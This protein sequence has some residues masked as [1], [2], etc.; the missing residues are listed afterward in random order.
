MNI[1]SKRWNRALAGALTLG[2]MLGCGQA[3]LADDKPKRVG[4]V[5]DI[6]GKQLNTN[7][8]S[9]DNRWYQ[10]YQS[11]PTLFQ[12]R[13]AAGDKT[14]AT[15]EFIVG[16]K[17]VIAPG[18]E[19]EIK[20]D[21]VMVVKSGTV[22]AQFDKKKLAGD[23]RKFEIRTAG[24]VMGIEGTEFI[25]QTNPGG[26]T[27]LTVIEGQVDVDGNKVGGGKRA[28]F[29]RTYRDEVYSAATNPI[30]S[31]RD[32]AFQNVDPAMRPVVNRAL[33]WTVGRTRLGR[34]FY[35]RNYWIARRALRAIDDPEG[36][37]VDYM[38]AKTPGGGMLRR[39]KKSQD[40]KPITASTLNGDIVGGLSW[41]KV[42]RTNQYAVVVANDSEA[43]D[44]VWYTTVKQS[45]NPSVKYPS[46][47]PELA[48]GKRYWLFVMPQKEK[49]GEY[50]PFY[51]K[52]RPLSYKG[53]FSSPGH[54][55]V[56]ADVSGVKAIGEAS[57][58]QVSWDGVNGANLYRVTIKDAAGNIVWS[59]EHDKS[60]YSYPGTARG[61]TPG[62]YV[63]SV[64][65]FDA[66]G[67]KMAETKS[68]VAFTS[69]GWTS[70]G[71]TDVNYGERTPDENTQGF[72]QN[73][74]SIFGNLISGF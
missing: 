34:F 31:I 33:W 18:T 3:V 20:D 46:Y 50:V 9:E 62:E 70:A 21:D 36:A 43:K 51:F 42:N 64:E 57:A 72:L 61:L 2:L 37:A 40:P 39:I 27:E 1:Y 53:S 69:A 45:K 74:G 44:V 28:Y 8:L 7:R 35:G 65:A 47:G 11:M 73:D 48:S 66:Q 59:D 60:P 38:A 56:F 49:K 55:P 16:G 13:L 63:A 32:A 58:P 54:S 67:L 12:E 29:G 5:I 25:V 6:D 26:T 10:A 17:A 22:W 23:N 19:V 30:G 71:A 52:K 68:P 14:T 4:T 41:K 15:V 24:G